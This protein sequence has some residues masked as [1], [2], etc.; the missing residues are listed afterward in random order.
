MQSQMFQML[1]VKG[2]MTIP[3]AVARKQILLLW[4]TDLLTI[5]MQMG[6]HLAVR[7]TFLA[8]EAGFLAILF[9]LMTEAWTWSEVLPHAPRI[10]VGQL[11]SIPIHQS[12]LIAGLDPLVMVLIE[13]FLEEPSGN[14]TAIVVRAMMILIKK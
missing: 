5:W 13:K 14:L 4:V 7:M 3:V 11:L 1:S 2:D 8:L 6:L 12:L 10:L 9:H